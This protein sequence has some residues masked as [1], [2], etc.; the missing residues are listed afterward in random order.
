MKLTITCFL[1]SVTII[2]NALPISAQD[3][4]KIADNSIYGQYQDIIQKSKR[5]DQG[6]K[7]IN[8]A[9]L[10]TFQRNFTDTL[11]QAKSR[12]ADVQSKINEQNKT[13]ASFK[14]ELESERKKLIE[15]K[16]QVDEISLLGIGV[17]K[18]AYNL[19]MWGLV[20]GL[21]AA[22]AFIIFQ[23][24]SSRKEANYRI[25]LFDELSEEFQTFKIKVNEKEKKLARE[26]QTERNRVDELLKH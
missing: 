1:L 2:I 21:S 8:P 11:R 9:R 20:I 17:T 14:I 13:L 25:K 10:S 5:N 18:L 19:I 16:L 12:L 24:S 22:L 7:I 23:S 3:T 4:T 6:L 15:S 26:L